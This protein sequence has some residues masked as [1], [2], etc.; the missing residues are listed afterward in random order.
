MAQSQHRQCRKKQQH[1]P[2]KRMRPMRV[3]RATSNAATKFGGS[4]A[5]LQ[6]LQSVLRFRERFSIVT[7]KK[8]KNSQ[9]TTIDML[10]G[11]VGMV[12]L[13]CDRVFHINDRFGDDELLA[14]QLGLVRI[15][16]Q[17]TAN[18][19]LR[20]FKKWHVKQL[21]R[22]LLR[23]VQLH[24]KFLT[25]TCRVLDIDASDVTRSTHKSQG[26]KPGR[27]KK[28]KGKDSYLMS[29]GFAGKQVVATDLRSGNVH[30]SQV[31]TTIFDKALRAM[32][33]IDLIRLDA[34]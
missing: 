16:D 18:R 9:F 26:A 28:G 14:K 10:F 17:S 3:Q 12:M 27:N 5:L 6:Y 23:M 21:E 30:C 1:S 19:F 8:G 13:G 22:I 29:C 20:R 4:A 32:T 33:R 24:G 2:R 25:F 7:I 31:L 34:G 15:F 11:L